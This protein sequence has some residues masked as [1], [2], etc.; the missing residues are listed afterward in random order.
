MNISPNPTKTILNINTSE[1]VE[2]ITIYSISGSLVKNIFKNV[3]QVNVEGLTQGMYILVVKTDNG[4]TRNRF[5][6]E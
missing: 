1:I 2:Q 3:N 4:I 6:K 5:I